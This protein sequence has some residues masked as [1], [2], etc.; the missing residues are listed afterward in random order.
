[1]NYWGTI[2][3]DLPIYDFENFSYSDL[4]LDTFKTK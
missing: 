2:D 4:W 3:S 1:M